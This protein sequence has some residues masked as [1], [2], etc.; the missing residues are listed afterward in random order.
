MTSDRGATF[1]PC[2][3][4]TILS[5]G[6]EE[7]PVATLSRF[8]SPNLMVLAP[9]LVPQRDLTVVGGMLAFEDMAKASV[10]IS[11]ADKTMDT[12]DNRQTLRPM[13]EIVEVEASV[14]L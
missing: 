1:L 8:I 11:C 2:P 13:Q 10:E 5:T 6:L 14:S 3:S 4:D 12:S 9:V 7:G